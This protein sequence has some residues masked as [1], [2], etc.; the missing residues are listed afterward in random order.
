[1]RFRRTRDVGQYVIRYS[2]SQDTGRKGKAEEIEIRTSTRPLCGAVGQVIRRVCAIVTLEHALTK[3][4]NVQTIPLGNAQLL[5]DI[6][7]DL[8][9]NVVDAVRDVVTE[10]S[11]S[12][13]DLVP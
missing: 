5:D 4:H 11:G 10:V 9:G 6:S 12:A 13:F 2:S 8:V 1:V 3:R 7:C